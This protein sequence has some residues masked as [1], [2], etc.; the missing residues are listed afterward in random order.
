MAEVRR[1]IR[2]TYRTFRRTP[3]DFGRGRLQ[4]LT[5]KLLLKPRHKR[6]ASGTERSDDHKDN[7]G[8]VGG[9]SGMHVRERFAY[10]RF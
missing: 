4:L 1:A 9:A 8:K 2:S 6:F 10:P 7:T 3:E 5:G